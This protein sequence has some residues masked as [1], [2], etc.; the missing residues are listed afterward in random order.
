MSKSYQS[1]DGKV[2]SL[3]LH[4]QLADIALSKANKKCLRNKNNGKTI[5]ETLGSTTVKHPQLN[6]PNNPKDI[7]RVFATSRIKI[8]EQAIIELYAYFADYVSGVIRE[9][10]NTNPNR[11][12]GL[13]PPQT[14]TD[15]SYKDVFVLGNYGSIL[16]EIAKRVF[17]SLEDERNTSKLLKKF[18]KTT[19]QNVP[20][21]IQQD[22]LVYLEIRHLII[23]N[24]SKADTK[25]NSM[26]N[27]G[28]V[29]VHLGNKKIA[30]NYA[31]TN[32]AIDAVSLL[33]K[34]MDDE[35]VR[36]GLI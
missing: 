5:G 4:I 1:F 26:N 7:G 28:L 25:F 35:L 24:N 21:N 30:I 20:V 14:P 31:L 6:I 11:I 2:R 15:L 23:H 34:T 3:K 8:N 27:H 29:A 32:S 17:R 12:L 22:A 33:C 19:K 13:I 18:I 36:L 9:F 16:D 10:E